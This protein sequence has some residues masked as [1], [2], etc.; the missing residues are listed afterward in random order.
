MSLMFPPLRKITYVLFSFDSSTFL[1]ML[2]PTNSDLTASIDSLV[3]VCDVV[4][5]RLVIS[6]LNYV[7]S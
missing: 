6:R 1:M 7:I 5:F 4:V 3:G 2:V